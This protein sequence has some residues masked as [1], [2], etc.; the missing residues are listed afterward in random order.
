ML[1]SL[2]E[3]VRIA[4]IGLRSNKLRAALTMLGITIGVA[5][6]VVMLS[7]GTSV[8]DFI[9]GEFE[10]LGA[11]LV[12]IIPTR[13][14]DGTLTPL[15]VADAEAL[16][17]PLRAPDL[18]RVMPQ[19]ADTLPVVYRGR[20]FTLNVQG[21]T[22]DYPTI[23][24]RNVTSGRY[25]DDAEAETAARVAVIGPKTAARLFEDTDPIGQ[26]VRINAVSFEVI[27]V[28]EAIGGGGQAGDQ[29]DLILVPITTAQTR[30]SGERILT[31]ERPV[32][33]ILAQITDTDRVDPALAQTRAVLRAE[34]EIPA[35]MNDDFQVISSTSILDTLTAII[36]LF[37]I[38]LGLIG[39]ISLL[40]GGIGVMNIM[41]VSVTER[42]REIGLRKAVGAQSR[43]IV[44]QFLV[45]AVVIAL[46]GGLIGVLIALA[47]ALAAGLLLAAFDVSVSVRADSIALALII[48]AGVGIFFGSYPARRAA[49]LHP[50]QALRYE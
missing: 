49:R 44:Q 20:S 21:V 34:R 45:E 2:L 41:L 9:R 40:V 33:V 36:G 11:D 47:G 31:G 14:D 1:T 50:I 12:L 32:A 29:D 25:F 19:T 6:V 13:G 22:A 15:T 5:A 4:L 28:L 38:F 18:L 30:L 10:A 42:T 39:G 23:R 3:N 8:E 48:S 35:G 17:D 37:T 27:G 46:I 24:S 7:I 16:A 43:D 26:F